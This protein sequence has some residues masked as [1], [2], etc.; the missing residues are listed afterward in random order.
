EFCGR[1]QKQILSYLYFNTCF[2]TCKTSA[3]INTS[4]S[5]ITSFVDLN[6]LKSRNINWENTFN[7]YSSTHFSNSE[8]LRCS[9]SLNLDNNTSKKL[10]TGFCAFLNFII[11]SDRVTC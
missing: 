4:S 5:Y 3:V 7:P 11:H 9:C 8:S 6:F 10:G 2:F 1:I